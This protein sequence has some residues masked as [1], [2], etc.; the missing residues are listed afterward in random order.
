MTYPRQRPCRRIGRRLCFP[1]LLCVPL[2]LHVGTPDRIAVHNA[3]KAER[4]GEPGGECELAR[5]R[6]E[7]DKEDKAAER[8]DGK[9]GPFRDV[10]PLHAL[11]VDRDA[12]LAQRPRHP[13][14]A[15]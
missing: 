1:R 15:Q 12:I 3:G 13:L 14:Q 8:A 9:P 5:A 4:D 10:Q 7:I 11:A 6:S 2:R